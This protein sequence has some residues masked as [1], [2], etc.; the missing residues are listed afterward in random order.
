MT[1]MQ[2]R[3][4]RAFDLLDPRPDLVDFLFDV[5]VALARINRFLGH[6]LYPWS[7]AQ[8]CVAGAD[9][10]TAQ[11]NNRLAAAFL[12]HDAHEA[13]LGDI[14]TPAAQAIG[15]LIPGGRNPI[16]DIKR[17]IDG[18][19]F[20]AAGLGSLLDDAAL[21]REVADLD[22]RLLRAERDAL[23]GAPPQP[24]IRAVETA[25]PIA[26][27]FR[28]SSPAV[29]AEIWRSRFVGYALPLAAVAVGG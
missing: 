12:L 28:P 1:W 19:I 27:A 15:A 6:T 18:A 4:N 10:A 11:G 2:T 13:Y 3:S 9:W 26:V 8:H 23:L 22:L 5:P 25:E 21:M 29:D 24:W 7:V 14:T 20:A 17:A 16:K